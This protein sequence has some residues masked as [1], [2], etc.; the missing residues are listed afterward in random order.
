MAATDDRTLNARVSRD[1]GD[2]GLWV[3]VAD[4]PDLCTF[5]LPASIRRGD[6]CVAVSTGGASPALAARLRRELEADFGPHWAPLLKL[7]RSIRRRLL[8]LGRAPDDNKRLFL[9]LAASDLDRPASRG[10]WDAVEKRV[11]DLFGPD[12]GFDR[13]GF[14]PDQELES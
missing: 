2:R 5:I 7:F 8:E 6:L 11:A 14:D 12:F 4:Q 9:E 3:N 13:L 10:D 1:A